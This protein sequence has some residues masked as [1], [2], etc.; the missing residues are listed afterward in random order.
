VLHQIGEHR[1]DELNALRGQL[2]VD[3]AT[4]LWMDV[5]A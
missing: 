2:D 1:I 4:I 5:P 3:A